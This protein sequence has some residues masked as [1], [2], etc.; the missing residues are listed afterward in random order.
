[1]R[2]TQAL[3]RINTGLSSKIS[4]KNGEHSYL[5]N[6]MLIFINATNKILLPTNKI[7]YF[8]D[9]VVCYDCVERVNYRGKE[10]YCINARVI[11]G[12]ILLPK[13]N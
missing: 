3:W 8:K 12:Q 11:G 4:Q 6:N 2:I 9:L 5:L 1:M 10:C 7:T 13:E